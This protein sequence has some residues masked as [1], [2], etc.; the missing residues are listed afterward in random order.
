M[1]YE[2][3]A[4]EYL[5]SADNV[6]RQIEEVKKRIKSA[7]YEKLPELNNSL[8]IL[9]EMYYD[10]MDTARLLGRRKGEC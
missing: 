8:N 3:W 6:K 9:T 5:E 10:C 4:R 7:T 1:T 2:Q